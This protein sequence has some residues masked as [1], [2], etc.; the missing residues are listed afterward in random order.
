MMQYYILFGLLAV[1]VGLTLLM[2]VKKLSEAS[3][4]GLREL[5]NALINVFL[6]VLKSATAKALLVLK[7]RGRK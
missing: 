5:V 3:K 2:N 7:L 4:K 1:I 6:E